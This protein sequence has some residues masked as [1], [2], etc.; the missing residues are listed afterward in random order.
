VRR[1]LCV[2]CCALTINVAC[3]RVPASRHNPIEEPIHE[4]RDGDLAA[5]YE[6]AVRIAGAPASA[7]DYPQ[8]AS[9]FRRAADRGHLGAQACLGVMYHRG[10]GV[11]RNDVEAIKWL[12]LATA[13]TSPERD[14]YAL[15][16]DYV[17]GEMSQAD[18]A[19]GERLARE[20]RPVP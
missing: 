10:Q 15:W 6:V 4:A 13:Q 14:A 2:A 19:E 1:V 3:S 18:V 8:A 5:Q 12:T 20:W 17:A 9:W 7:P 16:R 11:L